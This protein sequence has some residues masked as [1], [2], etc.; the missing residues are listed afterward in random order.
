M[1]KQRTKTKKSAVEPKPSLALTFES[2]FA[3][4][5]FEGRLKSWQQLEIAA[6]FKDA[7]LRDKEDLDTY[8]AILKK[9]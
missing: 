6:F 4:C 1:E 3:K 9:Y 8:E 2:F 5:V 7:G